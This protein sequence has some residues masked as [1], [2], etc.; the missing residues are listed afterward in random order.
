MLHY[1]VVTQFITGSPLQFLSFL[2]CATS[3]FFAIS[4]RLRT[5][6]FGSYHVAAYSCDLRMFG[7]IRL[8]HSEMLLCLNAFLF[9]KCAF[10]HRNLNVV[11]FA[12][13]AICVLDAMI[14]ELCSLLAHCHSLLSIARTGYSR[15]GSVF[16]LVLTS[17]V[18]L[19]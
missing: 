7:R 17:F 11:R 8:A 13:N 4:G 5:S 19:F 10:L 3:S 1:L 15:L 12:F 6:P 16:W 9:S 18:Y 14:W 2:C